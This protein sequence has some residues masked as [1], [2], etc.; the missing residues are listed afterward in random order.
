MIESR[1]T[2]DGN[3]VARP[4]PGGVGAAAGGHHQDQVL[5]LLVRGYTIV[6]CALEMK[7]PCSICVPQADRVLVLGA[8]NR[9]MDLDEAVVRRLP[10]RLLVDLPDV[11]NR[12]RI[13]KVRA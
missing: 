11:A 10:R 2:V 6:I 7:F 5:R 12:A 9:P 4:V 13:L 3:V 1:L 8:T